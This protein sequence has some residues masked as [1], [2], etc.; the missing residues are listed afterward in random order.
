MR[1]Q[2]LLHFV[3][4]HAGG[5]LTVQVR[6][7]A[8]VHDGIEEEGDRRLACLDSL[9]QSQSP[10][11]VPTDGLQTILELLVAV[12]FLPAAGVV[13]A[14][15]LVAAFGHGRDSQ[16]KLES[17]ER[18][19]TP[20]G[21]GVLVAGSGHRLVSIT[22]SVPT[23]AVIAAEQVQRCVQVRVDLVDPVPD[24]SECQPPVR[25]LWLL[26][27]GR[28]TRGNKSTAAEQTEQKNRNGAAAENRIPTRHFSRTS[29]VL[30]HLMSLV[31]SDRSC[32]TEKRQQ[33]S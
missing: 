14:V 15:V 16:I 33:R 17:E 19:A 31:S 10:L 23:E 26:F 2:L 25:G 11:H 5:P 20:I 1:S 27:T 28:N 8:Q 24:G 6:L 7:A 32:L 22:A 9:G 12:V 18:G 29:S 30:P 4:A 3:L 13:A 21:R